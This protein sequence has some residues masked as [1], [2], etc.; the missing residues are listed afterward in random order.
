[1]R[2]FKYVTLFIATLIVAFSAAAQVTTS[3]M[4]GIVKSGTGEILQGASVKITH[5]PTGTTV[6]ATTAANGRFVVSNLQPGGPYTVVV[7]YLGYITQTRTEVYLDLGETGREDFAMSNSSQELKEV[8]VTAAR[9]KQF[10]SGGVG[11]NISAERMQNM[12]TVGR[13]LTDFIRLTPQAKTT[14]GG[15]ISIAGQNNRY[16]R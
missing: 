6:T 1:M 2:I 7:T 10:V 8:V 12:P 11:T 4:S 3:S 15:G 16:N 9:S 14:F 5:V 13:N